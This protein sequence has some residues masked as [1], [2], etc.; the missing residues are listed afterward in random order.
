M[1][2]FY[3]DNHSGVAAYLQI[4]QQVKQ[5]LRLGLLASG[6]LLAMLIWWNNPSVQIYGDSFSASVYDT[7]GPV[8]VAAALLA[9]ALGLFAGT[10]TRRTVPAILLTIAL[11]VAIRVPVEVL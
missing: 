2:E 4:V 5:A 11:F 7:S 8:W 10:L 6:A 1:I 9:L 3:L